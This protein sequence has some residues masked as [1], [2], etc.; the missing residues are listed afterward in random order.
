MVNRNASLP[1]P[2]QFTRIVTEFLKEVRPQSAFN[3]P[4]LGLALD[5]DLGLDSLAR[6]ELLGRIEREFDLALPEQALTEAETLRDLW[7]L[8]QRASQALSGGSSGLR[9]DLPEQTTGEVQT[10]SH[11]RTLQEVLQWHGRR[12]PDRIYTRFYEDQ[13]EGE[14]LTFGSLLE[15]ASEMAAGLQLYGVS[16]GSAVALMLP[17]GPSYLLSFFAVQLA[18]GV[19]VPLY[20]PVRKN[21]IEDHLRRHRSIL[22]NCQAHLLITDTE[23][24]PLARLMRS[25]VNTL[26]DVVTPEG[27]RGTPPSEFPAHAPTDTAFLQ[28]TSG[29]TGA[30][31]GVV[32]NHV[33]L[34]SNI[35]AMGKRVQAMPDDI[36]VSWLPL[37]HDM[38]LIG[39]VLGSLYYGAQLVLLSPLQF[40]ARP[41]RWLRAIDRYRG[42]LSASPDFGYA[43]CLRA[44]GDK[45]LDGI[46]LRSWRAAFNGAEAINPDTMSTFVD[47]FAKFGFRP[48]AMMPV[49]GLAENSVGLAFP[50]LTRGTYVDRIDRVA[51][52][53]T[54]EARPAH[55]EGSDTVRIVGCGF[56]LD[57][58]DVRIVDA[59]GYEL[60]ERR[61]G[62][63]QFRGPSSTSGYY[64]NTEAT[65]DL[66]QDDW[67]NSGDLAYMA[68]GE[69]FI[70]GRVKDLI[71]RAGRNIYP[72]ELE[73]AIGE[74]PEVRT[75]NVAVFGLPA[76]DG[77]PEQLI[78]VAEARIREEE[79]RKELVKQVQQLALD[80]TS[81]P[82]D[83]VVLAEP[84]T[85][86]KTSSGKVRRSAC[87]QEYLAG[88]L[89]SRRTTNWLQWVRI[90][91]GAILPE[92]RRQMQSLGA[93]VF[94]GYGWGLFYGLAAMTVIGLMLLPSLKL[95]WAL[96][97]G[98]VRFLRWATRTPVQI[99]DPDRLPGEGPFIL[100]SNHMSYLDGYLLIATLPGPFS[101]VAKAELR[102]SRALEYLLGRMSVEFVERFDSRKGVEDADRLAR[103]AQE[104]RS[105]FFFPEGTFT[106]IPG[107]RPFR[108]GAFATAARANL[109][110]VPVAIRGTRNMLRAG[111]WFPRRGRLQVSCGA[112]VVSEPAKDKNEEAWT[113]AIALRDKARSF[114]LRNCG[115]PDLEAPMA[116]EEP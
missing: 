83:D 53:K 34:L 31:K 1:E 70:T 115:E 46:D 57:G 55:S 92:I 74:L 17:T 15:D 69:V 97:R 28:Y 77:Q 108:M 19:P 95:R 45:S 107:L 67:L 76:R 20:P 6:V 3:T 54:G 93:L 44:L 89:G 58:H 79:A 90:A 22:E 51:L 37:Y 78:V 43:L 65:R 36:F 26:E 33:N 105:L 32:L 91:T 24:Q 48:E 12:A 21:Q 47:R 2:D 80:I 30:P 71:I 49:Y 73:E 10:P 11:A 25:Q 16:T 87:Q 106:R 112:P 18:G 103:L 59:R 99:H 66:M 111:S 63:L 110:V 5:T 7:L 38:G 113:Q 98:A 27:L 100:V 116:P 85:V 96:A 41:Q 104:G 39:A 102:Q 29:S 40:I 14:V 23:I 94:A 4:D 88:S 13:G 109:P 61:E 114:I 75:G 50:P 8:L 82:A 9:Q 56:P 72:V 60:D 35:R 68:D 81:I 84:G 101:F 62:R 52:A 42:T 86:L 64:R